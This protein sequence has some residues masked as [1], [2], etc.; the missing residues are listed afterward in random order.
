M[1]KF[2]WILEIVL[3]SNPNLL[4]YLRIAPPAAGAAIASPVADAHFG[5]GANNSGTHK[6]KTQGFLGSSSSSR[7]RAPHFT[8]HPEKKLGHC[9]IS[10]TKHQPPAAAPWPPRPTPPP[11]S[12]LPPPSQL[13]HEPAPGPSLPPRSRSPCASGLGRHQPSRPP[14]RRSTSPRWPRRRSRPRYRSAWATASTSTAWS[15]TS[16]SSSAASTSPTTAAAR[17]TLTVRAPAR[18]TLTVPA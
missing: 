14:S 17:L 2:N 13:R 11:S 15:P 12:W 16:R 3:H 4:E 7:S 1:T 18:L 6:K 5:F 9:A 10:P 8:E